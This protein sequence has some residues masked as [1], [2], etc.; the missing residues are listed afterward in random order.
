MSHRRVVCT[1]LGIISPLG[2]TPEAFVDGLY[3]GRSAI[4]RWRFVEDDRVYAKVGGDLSD[5]DAEAGLDALRERIPEE[6]HRRA[7]KIFRTA[8]FSTRL[9]ILT[10]VAA[11]LDAGLPL[12]PDEGDPWR[13]GV[14][15]GGHNLNENYLL[16][17]QDVFRDEPDWIDSLSALLTLDT[18][19]AGSVSEILGC[20]GAQYSVGGACASANVA[21][22]NAVDEIRHHEHDVVAV[23][24]ATLDFSPMGLHA[25]ALM[26][27]ITFQSFNDTPAAASR[28]YDARR[29]GF[30]PSHG[31]AALVMEEYEHAR[32]RGAPIYGEVLGV[33]ATS[34][35]NHLTNPSSEGQEATIR[36]VLEAARVAPEEIDFVS[37]HATS[38]PLGDLSELEALRGALGRHAGHVKIN[39]PKSML[40]HT[41]WSAPS[42][43]T[44]AALLQMR[45]RRLHGS[46]NIDELDPAVDLDVCAS[47]PVDHEVNVFLKNAF[48]FGGTNCCAVWRK[49]E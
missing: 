5:Y 34:D 15:V 26:G 20:R 4:R 32:A 41:C 29:E 28:P 13:R 38:T 11:W 18:D 23:V 6:A 7:R 25:M 37:A 36:R 35:A 22:K 1:G 30:V 42:V 14:L 21:L 24:G 44:V 45:N 3:A 46:I 9:T 47:G 2:S 39:A 16:R 33:V 27:A 48:G 12:G 43:E 10:A 31:T 8:P 40:G 19:H 17:N 49:V